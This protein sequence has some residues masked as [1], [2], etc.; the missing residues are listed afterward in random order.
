[1]KKLALATLATALLWGCASV[2]MKPVSLQALSD[3]QPDPCPV[4]AEQPCLL[5][6]SR[7]A[8]RGDR[9]AAGEA[10]IAGALRRTDLPQ[11]GRD[12]AIR[13][14]LWLNPAPKLPAELH[15]QLRGLA[16]GLQVPADPVPSEAIILFKDARDTPDTKAGKPTLR[17]PLTVPAGAGPLQGDALV[18]QVVAAAGGVAGV[19]QRDRVVPAAPLTYQLLGLPVGG[20]AGA[21]E[22]AS[23]VGR[24]DQLLR[25]A[26][27]TEAFML[28]QEAVRRHPEGADLCSSH[29]AL[30]YMLHRAASLASGELDEAFIDAFNKSELEPPEAQKPVCQYINEVSR[31]ES[32]WRNTSL[33][34]RPDRWF[35]PADRQTYQSEME[36]LGRAFPGLPAERLKLFGA[37]AVAYNGQPDGPCDDGFEQR[38]E[39]VIEDLYARLEGNGRD[40]LA[41]FARTSDIFDDNY[42]IRPASIRR[43]LAWLDQPE[44]RWYRLTGA[45][46]ALAVGSVGAMMQGTDTTALAPVCNLAFEETQRLIAQDTFEGF[47]G[48]NNT[49]LLTSLFPLMTCPDQEQ[50]TALVDQVLTRS[51]E[52]GDGRA[53]IL[54]VITS[55]GGSLL[56]YAFT[57]RLQQGTQV[58]F[59]LNNGLQRVRSSLGDSDE[60]KALIAVIHVIRALSATL[61]QGAN[62]HPTLNEA[63]ATFAQV[64]PTEANP[65][66]PMMLRLAPALRLATR[67]VQGLV[68]LVQGDTAAALG[69]LKAMD[70]N[71]EA[72]L[73]ILLLNF[74]QP[75]HS[76]AVTRLIRVGASLVDLVESPGANAGKL[77]ADLATTRTRGEAE[78][79]W[80]AVGLELGRVV[81]HDV[82]AYVIAESDRA[83]ADVALDEGEV[84]LARMV[85]GALDDFG[86]RGSDWELLQLAPPLHTALLTYL[87]SNAEEDEA[88]EAAAQTIQRPLREALVRV[89]QTLAKNANDDDQGDTVQMLVDMVEVAATV[90]IENLLR[91][92]A[93][94][95]N[96]AD[97]VEKKVATYPPE[98]RSYAQMLAGVL[99]LAFGDNPDD[100]HASFDRAE[101]SALE[102]ALRQ[103]AYLPKAFEANGNFTQDNPEHALK[104]INE[105]LKFGEPALACNKAHQTH[106]ILPTKAWALER[107]G[108]HDEA[109]DALAFYKRLIDAGFTGDGVVQCKIQSRRAE[110]QAQINIEDRF[111]PSAP[112]AGDGTF[113]I[114]FGWATGATGNQDR[115]VC[116]GSPLATPRYDRIIHAYLARAMYAFRAGDDKTAHLAL[117][118][119]LTTGRLLIHGSP[120]SLGV[121]EA[122]GLTESRQELYLPLVHI[123]ALVARTRGHVHTARQLDDLARALAAAQDTP[124]LEQLP[125]GEEDAKEDDDEEEDE[126]GLHSLLRGFDEFKGLPGLLRATL[127]AQK[128]DDLATLKKTF[129]GAA[130]GSRLMPTWGVGVALNIHQAWIG[131]LKEA[132]EAIKRVRPPRRD[133]A[134]TA[135]IEGWRLLLE[136]TNTRK[137]TDTA[138][139]EPHIQALIQAG[140]YNEASELA[141]RMARILVEV[142]RGE[143][144]L[145]L[146]QATREAMGDKAPHIAYMDL[147]RALWAHWDQRGDVN[148][149][150]TSLVAF[151]QNQ[152]GRI[153]VQDEL[154]A[155]SNMIALL[156]RLGRD[157]QLLGVI[158]DVTLMVSRTLGTRDAV[159][160]RMRVVKLA[161]TAKQGS[162][163]PDALSTLIKAR[164]DVQGLDRQTEEVLD[165]L[166]GAPPAEVGAIAETYLRSIFPGR[167]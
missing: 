113:Q 108:R 139:V 92:D 125:G 9:E 133:P 145:K 49:R 160:F 41:V 138:K 100:A 101:A 161:L 79:R 71:L 131:E 119:A 6:L 53:G 25:E 70:T 12:D 90:G 46:G 89:Q 29:A 30:Q 81:L 17:V 4:A 13:L 91:G 152:H 83:G 67:G 155:S 5:T 132:G 128:P 151:I 122:S 135:A 26:R 140:L 143:E 115:I 69:A 129:E 126:E 78:Q 96:F 63:A 66:A 10:L 35:S 37:W 36:A 93:G 148:S 60:D 165:A 153:P 112:G 7:A 33:E 18:A 40:D 154:S 87:T 42:Q 48:R 45:S 85:E 64:T 28:L 16:Q 14:G 123:T 105:V 1:M 107:L 97:H 106:G 31:F 32:V 103:H 44:R 59:A 114:G 68:H 58:L 149:L 130:R 99:K 11:E 72:D 157:E 167:P 50:S 86:L 51:M 150:A 21:W 84:I 104:A 22:S 74:E 77:K 102:G 147:D 82:F 61:A 137:P 73:K 146:V 56:Q 95:I 94:K 110:L 23:R 27:P 156:G 19:Y 124:L 120:Q 15:E 52:G 34:E 47:T 142:N 43:L 158:D 111:S 38:K 141:V 163:D 54:A 76:A 121:A 20:A 24:A 3:G 118:E 8:Q 166:K 80:W 164:A 75:D 134:A 109:D 98:Q 162:L 55:T 62:P 88:M 65:E 144:G 117:L 127:E 159:V 39:D 2:E 57:G 116:V 136:A